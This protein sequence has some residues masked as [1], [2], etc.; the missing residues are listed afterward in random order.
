MDFNCPICFEEIVNFSDK[1]TLKCEHMFHKKCINNIK[2][3]KYNN[4]CP[5]CKQNN[6]NKNIIYEDKKINEYGFSIVS[7]RKTDIFFK[8]EKY[9]GDEE[10]AEFAS[11]LNNNVVLSG[12][13]VLSSILNE[14][15]ENNDIDIYIDEQFQYINM[16]K[17]LYKSNFIFK[18]NNT[19]CNTNSKK[20]KKYNILS[21][22]PDTINNTNH[23]I[24][25]LVDTF[26]HKDDLN[27][28]IDIIYSENNSIVIKEYFDLDIVKNY[29][30]GSDFYVYNPTKLLY[31]IDDCKLNTLN[32]KRQER[33]E[34]YRNRGFNITIM[35]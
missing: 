7:L 4:I 18:N 13:F 15:Y 9:F 5:L 1:M 21:N 2:N 26:I 3:N 29:F 27:L 33:I 23:D 14:Q 34:K 19:T 10:L 17:F 31:K 24:I 25:H 28:K 35:N 12:S 6:I 22:N 8:L 32:K 30:N 20:Y 16:L 11:Y